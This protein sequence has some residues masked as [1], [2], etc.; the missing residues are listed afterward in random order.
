M[1]LVLEAR[2][3]LLTLPV[4]RRRE[5]AAGP[6]VRRVDHCNAAR[7]DAVHAP[8]GVGRYWP[9]VPAPHQWREGV[10]VLTNAWVRTP[11]GRVSQAEY[12]GGD[13]NVSHGLSPLVRIVRRFAAAAVAIHR[14][15]ARPERGMPLWIVRHV[16]RLAARALAVKLV[17]ARHSINSGVL[18]VRLI[19]GAG[20]RLEAR[21]LVVRHIRVVVVG[22][23]DRSRQFRQLGRR[24]KWIS[25]RSL[26]WPALRP[27]AAAAPNHRSPRRI[28]PAPRRR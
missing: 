13:V 21:H 14:V 23:P 15:D 10:S 26:S 7:Q 19:E 27:L 24:V 9:T 4:G 6:P 11:E 2:Q 12:A 16:L 5:Q 28:L 18:H 1:A 17:E 20:Q 8:H 3:G 22:P 25:H